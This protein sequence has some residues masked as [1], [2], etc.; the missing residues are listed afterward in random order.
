MFYDPNAI[1]TLLSFGGNKAVVLLSLGFSD[2]TAII[3]EPDVFNDMP[4]AIHS[5]TFLNPEISFT[6]NQYFKR[7]G[8]PGYQDSFGYLEG[9]P[10]EM[11]IPLERLVA[12]FM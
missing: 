2:F 1:Q 7:K 6:K 4:E 12:I 8:G 9:F 3:G 11:A 5:R 10:R